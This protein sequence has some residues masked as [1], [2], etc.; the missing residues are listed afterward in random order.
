MKDEPAICVGGPLDGMRL[1]IIVPEHCGAG[2][3][4]DIEVMYLVSTHHIVTEET[5]KNYK[6]AQLRTAIYKTA[7]FKDDVTRL[8]YQHCIVRGRRP[9]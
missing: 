7:H 3:E 5:M 8:I 1:T 2:Q 9:K 4:C 6:R